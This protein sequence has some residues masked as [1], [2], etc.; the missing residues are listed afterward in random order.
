M[1]QIGQ[2]IASKYTLDH[3]IFLGG[4]ATHTHSP[5]AGQGSVSIAFRR[6]L[7]RC[8]MNISMLDMYSLSWKLNLVEKGMADASI[9]LPTYEHERKGIAEELLKFDA[10]YSRLFSGRSPATMLAGEEA[11]AKANGG[12]AVDAQRFIETFKKNA[13]SSSRL[14]VHL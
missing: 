4:D 7:I 3:R 5:K 11:H 9:L 10:E 2:R 14:R 8:R 13:V 12:V 1:Y 6:V